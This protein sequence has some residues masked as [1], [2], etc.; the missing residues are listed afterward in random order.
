MSGTIFS[1]GK[2]P[3]LAT[4]TY[5]C[6]FGIDAVSSFQGSFQLIITTLQS[7][8]CLARLYHSAPA[9]GTSRNSFLTN[10]HFI[11]SVISCVKTVF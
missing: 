1:R 11:F 2:V 5:A 10:Y 3:A 7:S 6:I 8:V 9:P 4:S